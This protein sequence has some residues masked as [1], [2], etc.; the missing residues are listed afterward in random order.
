EEFVRGSREIGGLHTMEDLAKWQVKIEEPLSAT[1]KGIEVFK[2]NTW[3]QGPVLLQMLNLI[4]PLDVG[5]MGY[6]STRYIHTLCQ[7]IHLAF[8]DRDF[9]YGDPYFPPEEP[10]RGLLSKGYARERATLIDG[11]RNDPEARPGD[12]YPFEGKRNPFADLLKN[13]SN[14]RTERMRR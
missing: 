9:Y 5:E 12:P 11:S 1:Y 6:N 3:T 8:A 10:V 7:V 2:L 4:E 13:W 14:T